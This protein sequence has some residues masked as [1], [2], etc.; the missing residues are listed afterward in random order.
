M[1]GPVTPDGIPF[2]PDG[3][4]A[5]LS[6]RAHERHRCER[7]LVSGNGSNAWGRNIWGLGE[8]G[9]KASGNHNIRGIV[10]KASLI[11]KRRTLP[12][13]DAKPPLLH[14][15]I[16]LHKSISVPA[17]RH[18]HYA[19]G[20]STENPHHKTYVPTPQDT[21]THTAGHTPK[22]DTICLCRR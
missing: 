8:V 1:V 14:K 3:V 16:Y 18:A 4:F 5:V 21:L 22:I 19:R 2:I 9:G 13:F 10:R 12:F 7:G 15:C 17:R 6:G 20:R 11:N